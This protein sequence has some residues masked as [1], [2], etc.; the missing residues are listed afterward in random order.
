M[1][2]TNSRIAVTTAATLA[3]SVLTA[4]APTAAVQKQRCPLIFGH[5]GYPK[6]PDAT[7]KDRIRQANNPSALRD[8]RRWGAD[9]VEAD[10]Q[11]TKRG[12]K[13]VMWHNTTT[14]GLNGPRRA[15]T[16]LYW[17]TGPGALKFR[18]ISRGPY[19]GERVYTL[20]SWLDYAAK[21][22]L[23][24]LLEVKPMAKRILASKTYGK[25]AWRQLSG[26]ILERQN[27]QPIMVY[28]FDPWIQEQL[29]K[30]HPSLLKDG[31]ARWTDGVS[32]DEPPPGWKG[33]TTR[34]QS[35]FKL[36]PFSV[37]TNYPKQYRRW[38]E[39]RCT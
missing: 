32:W 2:R 7:V 17:K 8:M 18:R 11:L 21:L 33:N 5:G 20:R 16:D 19:K 12:T 36:R 22:R 14:N 3:V 1:A 15:I 37:M 4:P 35:I 26:P 29:S 23:I 24:V 38:M 31:H 6:G 10:V 25:E 27:D 39:R 34:W 28:S 9:G 30:R 13:A